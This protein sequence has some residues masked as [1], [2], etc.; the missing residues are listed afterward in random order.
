MVL[1]RVMYWDYAP[2]YCP[3]AI[4]RKGV[5]W[6]GTFTSALLH[7]NLEDTREPLWGLDK[8]LFNEV[9]VYTSPQIGMPVELRN[10]ANN[11]VDISVTEA[12]IR[13]GEPN[14]VLLHYTVAEGWWCNL[15]V[16]AWCYC[17]LDVEATGDV[18]FWDV[19]KPILKRLEEFLASPIG[20]AAII[21]M[22]FI[23]LIAL[24]KS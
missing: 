21:F 2:V 17:Y 1:K 6:T 22:A 19:E 7:V 8:V 15:G 4:N 10:R 9:E 24:V 12:M 3:P 23:F 20:L 13:K 11:R 5:D 14:E 16:R 18:M